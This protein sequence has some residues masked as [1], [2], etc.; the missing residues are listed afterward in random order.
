[1]KQ[2][3]ILKEE[4]KK[5]LYQNGYLRKEKLLQLGSHTLLRTR[6]LVKYLWENLT[7]DKVKEII[8]WNT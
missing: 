2:F 4:M 5:W 1:M 6:N 3:V 8:I 7:N